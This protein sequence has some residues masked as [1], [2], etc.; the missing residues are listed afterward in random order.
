MLIPRTTR[1][2]RSI[3]DASTHRGAP[4]TQTTSP[5]I[6]NCAARS[7]PEANGCLDRRHSLR[8]AQVPEPGWPGRLC[9][10]V[11]CRRAHVEG[12]RNLRPARRLYL[13]PRLAESLLRSS[14][15]PVI[16]M[17]FLDGSADKAAFIR[18][19]IDR[20]LPG[21]L[22]EPAQAEDRHQGLQPDPW[23]AQEREAVAVGHGPPR[24][25]PRRSRQA[26]RLISA[27]TTIGRD[28]PVGQPYALGRLAGLPEHI[29]RYA[30]RIPQAPI[31]SHFG[32]SSSTIRLA[33]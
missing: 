23:L 2:C 3:V 10:S 33:M 13:A 24:E 26:C 20:A 6:S 5:M 8:P 32:S 11:R 14:S 29:D 17:Q 1:C 22:Q 18:K 7:Y 15:A 19:S 30:A 27:A 21:K 28:S 16:Q 25:F 9:S 12:Y 31:L 4:W